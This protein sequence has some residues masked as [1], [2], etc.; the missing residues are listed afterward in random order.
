MTKLAIN[1]HKVNYNIDHSRDGYSY[2]KSLR[3]EIKKLKREKK[4]LEK[5]LLQSIEQLDT[6]TEGIRELH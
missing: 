5:Q 2:I 6:L 4:Q 1:K 3:Q